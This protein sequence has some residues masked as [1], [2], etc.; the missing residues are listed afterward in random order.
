[1]PEIHL[2]RVATI[3][4][5][6]RFLAAGGN[7]VLRAMQSAGL[8][9]ELI[10][11]P[12]AYIPL[13]R[14]T[15]FVQGVER[16]EGIESFGLKVGA[17]TS[18]ED[19]GAFGRALSRSLSLHD[20]LQRIV[21][22][23]PEVDTGARAWIEPVPERATA[24]LCVRHEVDIGKHIADDYALALLINVVR[25]GAGADW[26]PEHVR[27][28]HARADARTRI[29]S[30]SEAKIEGGADH[31]GFEIPCLL[32]Q[33]RFETDRL[34]PGGGDMADSMGA[35]PTDI[36]TRIRM[37]IRSGFGTRIPDILEAS[38]M[39]GTSVRSL[40]RQLGRQG[41]KFRDLVNEE[42]FHEAERLLAEPGR[43]VAE[44]A[45][46]LGYPDPA[47]FSHAFRRWTGV[48][49]KNYRRTASV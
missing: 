7:E 41:Y 1:M 17:E 31:A 45:R 24:R 26:R 34:A 15:A 36:V 38:E 29:E 37:A 32:L 25:H 42:R 4:P 23:V 13:R 22:L 44:I 49:P 5:F 12:E 28:G 40:Q 30:L 33:N 8:A 3:A 20:A 35:P 43:P 47:N 46:H 18:L 2:T 14:A 6:P 39:A 10:Q 19:L 11:S 9:P 27:R 16:R 21:R 48:A